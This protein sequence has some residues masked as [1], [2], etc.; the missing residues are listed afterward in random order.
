MPPGED[1][2]YRLNKRKKIL[3]VGTASPDRDRI[4]TFLST[5]GWACSTISREQELLA[6]VWCEPFDAVLMLDLD[7]SG[8]CPERAIVVI[9]QIRP[10]LLERIIAISRG[11]LNPQT[12][13]LIER[14][15]LA[16]LPYERIFS[17]LCLMLEN[18]RNEHGAYAS[19]PGKTRTAMLVFDSLRLPPPAG[20]R[21]SP[22]PGRHLTYKCDGT[23]IEMFLDRPFGEERISLAGQVLQA[24]KGQQANPA[25]A[26]VLVDQSGT[27]ARTTTSDT[28]E[29]NL[30]FRSAENVSLEIRLGERSWVSIPLGPIDWPAFQTAV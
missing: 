5:M 2:E 3:L 17:Q 22:A 9:R 23:F 21:T 1:L 30:A 26:V 6:A 15:N 27:L 29:F 18:L 19:R 25:L 28:G 4:S 24:T 12:S 7:G 20:L 11:N 16:E 10:S 13:E 14:Y 8:V